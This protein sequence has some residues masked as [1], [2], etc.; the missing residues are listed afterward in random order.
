MKDSHRHSQ[1]HS[2]EID[3]PSR[4][5]RFWTKVI[6]GTKDEC[7]IWT[8][9]KDKKGYGS[10][11]VAKDKCNKAHIFSWVLHFGLVPKGLHV[12]H[13]CENESCVNPFHLQLLTNEKNNEKS[14]SP[15]AENKRKTHC[16]RGHPF[17]GD[18]LYVEPNGRRVCLTCKGARETERRKRAA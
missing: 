6:V 15:S 3:N 17:E 8:G 13:K 18:N 5:L 10:F 14:S 2:M 12:D 4:V 9:S 11:R 1:R 16:H 7:W